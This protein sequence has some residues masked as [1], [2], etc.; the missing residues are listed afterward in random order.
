MTYAIGLDIGGTNVKAVAINQTGDVL[1]DR[2]VPTQDDAEGSWKHDARKL[3]EQ[4]E[5]ARGAKASHIGVCCPGIAASDG[6]SIWWMMGKM[7][8]TMGFEWAPFLG[9]PH[10]IPVYNDAQAALLGE[11]CRGA[12]RGARNAVLLTLGTG[13]GG[14][15]LCDGHLL[16]GHLGRAG[17]LGHMSVDFDGPRDLAMTPGAIEYHIGNYSLPERSHGRWTSTRELVDAY[18]AGDPFASSVWLRSV[19]ALAAHI[20]SVVNAVDPEVVILGGGIALADEHLYAPLNSFLDQY[21][22]RPHGRRVK[23]VPAALGAD[24][25][26]VGAAYGAMS[27]SQ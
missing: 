24:A 6:K 1:D 25:G 20:V 11:I 22:W 16:R 23:I 5:Q 8:A 7:E 13:V 19:K 9:R 3:L 2:D 27:Q 10:A 14:A 12:A 15:V 21:E 17:H 18:A 26:A 4:M